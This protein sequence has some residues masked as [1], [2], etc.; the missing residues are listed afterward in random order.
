MSR[1]IVTRPFARIVVDIFLLSY[2]QTFEQNTPPALS[3]AS[4]NEERAGRRPDPPFAVS[5]VDCYSPSVPVG[6]SPSSV[7]PKPSVPNP[8]SCNCGG[9]ADSTGRIGSPSTKTSPSGS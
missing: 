9:V 7:L 4:K 2:F 6:P 3:L 5:L 8:S 1:G